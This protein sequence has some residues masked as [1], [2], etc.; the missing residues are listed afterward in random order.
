[1]DT[2]TR[3]TIASLV[4]QRGAGELTREDFFEKLTT[5]QLASATA[6]SA[7]FEPHHVD[8][9]RYSPYSELDQTYANDNPR[10][11]SS[12]YFRET[13]AAGDN[14]WPADA[15]GSCEEYSD[16][17]SSGASASLAAALA[18]PSPREVWCSD[19]EA[20]E[21]IPRFSKDPALLQRYEYPA[22]GNARGSFASNSL[23]SEHHY[24][25]VARQGAD[26][27]E[28]QTA[29][30]RGV[31]PSP[32]LT[33]KN[34]RGLSGGH[35]GDA[36]S[37]SSVRRNV[38]ASHKE[39]VQRNFRWDL[40]RTQRCQELRRQRETQ[41]FA[42][43]SFHPAVSSRNSLTQHEVSTSARE[44]RPAALSAAEIAALTERL[45]QPSVAAP[46]L[47]MDAMQ[48]REKRELE[49]LQHCTF[50]PN[51]SKSSRSFQPRNMPLSTTLSTCDAVS[52]DVDPLECGS[53]VAERRAD[54][55]MQDR[56]M[57]F[58][59]LTNPVPPSMCNA[60]A[61]LNDN[62]F[63]RLTRTA[64]EAQ[65]SVSATTRRRDQRQ[66][67]AQHSHDSS[68]SS[69]PTPCTTL[70]RC[71]SEVGLG[72]DGGHAR[73][74]NFLHR[75]SH[76]EEDRRSRLARLEQENTPAHQPSLCDRSIRLAE[77]QRARRGS[78]S[79]GRLERSA[80]VTSDP[81]ALECTFKPKITREAAKRQPRSVE[82]LS[83][84]DQKRR[85]A[86]VEKLRSEKERKE[87]QAA[88]YVHEVKDY[89]GVKSRLRI[90]E[91]PDTYVE[92]MEKVRKAA[93]DRV[94]KDA[95]RGRDRELAECTFTPVVRPAPDFVRR[96][97][98]SYRS[99]RNLKEKEKENLSQSG[100]E[101]AKP[102]W[103]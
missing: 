44:H 63:D 47:S 79:R 93:A 54:E 74:M 102:E 82:Q 40:Q 89:N 24:D 35:H 68:Y 52:D 48:W 39:F 59:P 64:P 56:S 9:A 12:P 28:L 103:R 92:R 90:L 99:V 46:R 66:H 15:D 25:K 62:V 85:Q 22:H 38:D 31:P 5:L 19:N 51:V 53:S 33:P 27:H 98:E 83:A 91:D 73:V 96:M 71:H 78:G 76:L 69:D 13:A 42:E 97:A 16:R 50:R 4:R 29:T 60:R 20:E 61:Y 32:P 41:E 14:W 17:R 70:G 26:V 72:G 18:P 77:R 7:P 11:F 57:S 84:G 80:S 23:R 55:A 21:S 34:V 100:C 81:N 3:V 6:D 94:A 88:N 95:A 37:Q 43:C 65:R 86:R 2:P 8:D 101:V 87:Q 45:A 58:A 67:Y 49:E 36:I 10:E 30:E 1:M 75:Q